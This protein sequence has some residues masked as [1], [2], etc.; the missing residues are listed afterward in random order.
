MRAA[1]LLI[2]PAMVLSACGNSPLTMPD[3]P[4]ERAA[5]CGLAELSAARIAEPIKTLPV[6]MQGRVYHYALLAA[7]TGKEYQADTAKAVIERT[8][9]VAQWGE[10]QKWENLA[11]ECH[12]LYPQAASTEASPK[13]PDDPLAATAGCD[14]LNKF[15]AA[16]LGSQGETY[17]SDMGKFGAIS[18]SADKELPPMYEKAGLKDIQQQLKFRREQMS[19]FAKL[20]TPIAVLR[21]CLAAAKP[22]ID[23]KE[24]AKGTKGT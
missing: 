4:V 13:L 1:T 9:Q 8:Q 12:K 23:A 11:P 21:V 7:S 17:L 20:G 14:M 10:E 5:T 22:V 19:N 3:D 16:A 24:A 15:M 2:P 18:L 6:E